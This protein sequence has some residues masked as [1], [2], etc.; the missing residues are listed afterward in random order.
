MLL[1]SVSALSLALSLG[2]AAPPA[3]ALS[4]TACTRCRVQLSQQEEKGFEMP[5]LPKLEMP[6]FELPKLEMPDFLNLDPRDGS[7]DGASAPSEL[8]DEQR[9][10]PTPTVVDAQGVVVPVACDARPTMPAR[11]ASEEL[12][13]VF[14]TANFIWPLPG[15]ELSATKL[16]I[17]NVRPPPS[18]ATRCQPVLSSAHP[19]AP[20]QVIGRWDSVFQW[21]K[22]TEFTVVENVKEDSLDQGGTKQRHETAIKLKCAER[23]ALMYNCKKLP[24]TN[25]AL[26]ASVGMTCDEFNELAVSDVAVNVVFDSLVESKSSLVDFDAANARRAGWV[27][28]DGSL[29]ELAFNVGMFKSRV[30]VVLSWFL[31]GKGN[32]VWVLI[33]AQALHD[34]RPDLFPTPKELDLFKIFAIV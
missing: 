14:K 8:T 22:R 28:A 10:A 30:L 17:L 24:F 3:R 18:P 29:N 11:V 4:A 20:S 7:D 19:R 5:T 1:A 34:A 31:L 23:C 33:A 32:W 2:P 25:E 12:S 27:N 15:A 16:E 9:A 21:N 26:A 13:K 6:S